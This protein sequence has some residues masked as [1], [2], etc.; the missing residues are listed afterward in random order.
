MDRPALIVVA[1]DYGRSSAYDAGIVDAAEAGAVD[2]VSA[3]VL[4]DLDPGAVLSTDVEIGLHLE[5]PRW[6]GEGLATRRAG[7][8][9]R[10][11]S[12]A[13]LRD[14]LERFRDVFGRPP[15]HLDG[16]HHCHAA[17]RLV[18]PLAR[19]AARRGLPVRS[20]SAGHRRT[21]RRFGVPTPDRLIGRLEENEPALPPELQLVIE[22]GGEAPTGVTEW[23]VHPGRR[24]PAAGSAYDAGREEDLRL[25]LELADHEHLRTLRATHARALR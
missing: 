23:M 21:L 15:A 24:D 22:G 17:P 13:A 12:V 18:A 4:G 2:A 3:I 6:N 7:P 8:T 11:A 14:Q 25:L 9:E 16:H 10:R 19:Q 5:L 20:V 1:D